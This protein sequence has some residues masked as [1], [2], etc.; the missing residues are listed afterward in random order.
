[1]S[2]WMHSAVLIIRPLPP[3]YRRKDVDRLCQEAVRI[4]AES[5]NRTTF[6]ELYTFADQLENPAFVGWIV[7]AD[8][9]FQLDTAIKQIISSCLI[10]IGRE[11]STDFCPPMR[12]HKML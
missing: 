12:L 11:R 6:E 5:A 1:M 4:Q 2:R 3:F 9:F 8:F 10:P 7:E